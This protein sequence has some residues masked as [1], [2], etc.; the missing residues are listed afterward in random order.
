MRLTPRERQVED[1]LARQA[2]DFN[3]VAIDSARQRRAEAKCALMGHMPTEIGAVGD[4]PLIEC[5]R[6]GEALDG[7]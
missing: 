2:R 7:E 3:R 1:Y 4:E 6:C 5:S